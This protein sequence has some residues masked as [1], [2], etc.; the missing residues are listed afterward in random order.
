MP[1]G[2]ITKRRVEP[3]RGNGISVT[4]IVTGLTLRKQPR[5]LH[6]TH[7]VPSSAT[8]TSYG[9]DFGFGALTTL[10]SPVFGLSRP[11]KFDAW[12]L[13]NK[14]PSLLKAS[15]CG[16]DFGSGILKTVA[17]PVAGSTHPTVPFLLPENQGR[18]SL[19]SCTV[20]GFESGGS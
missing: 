8:R 7:T 1:S 3:P 6:E 9:C 13:K 14:I 19:S 11:I 18:P 5:A 16:S 10:I 12:K 17:L 4:S 20:C 15:V 2:A